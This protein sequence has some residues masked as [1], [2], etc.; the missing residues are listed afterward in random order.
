MAGV[1]PGAPQLC[2]TANKSAASRTTIRSP[3][4]I[5]VRLSFETKIVSSATDYL[6]SHL[7]FESNQRQSG[8]AIMSVIGPLQLYM[9]VK[10]ESE[11]R[12]NDN[13]L[14]IRRLKGLEIWAG[15]LWRARERHKTKILILVH[16]ASL[17]TDFQPMSPVFSN[18][19][20]DRY[21]III[22]SD[23]ALDW[24]VGRY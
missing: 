21:I 13:Y 18:G 17:V 15:N 23:C 14:S 12:T 5:Q 22:R 1:H 9:P 20:P 3:V 24:H 4:S 8:T 10:C 7:R 16:P 2:G 11:L 19:G 6:L